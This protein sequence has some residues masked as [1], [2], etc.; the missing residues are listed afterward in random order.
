MAREMTEQKIEKVR[1]KFGD[2]PGLERSSLGEF[3]I[4]SGT[5]LSSA[6]A[7]LVMQGAGIVWLNSLE[8]AWVGYVPTYVVFLCAV[9]DGMDDFRRVEAGV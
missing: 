4:Y 6:T 8:G 9:G 1:K 5:E 7:G 2:Q 3:Q